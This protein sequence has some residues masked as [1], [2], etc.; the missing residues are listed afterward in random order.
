MPR[1][2]IL[3]DVHANLEAFEAVL[4]DLEE[5][6]VGRIYY[7][8]DVVV[9]GPN[10][11]ECVR[12]LKRALDSWPRSVAIR[13]NNDDAIAS[14]RLSLEPA[15]E[16]TELG[17]NE[18]ISTRH[19]SHLNVPRHSHEWTANLMGSEE[20]ALLKDLPTDQVIEDP[21]YPF[22][23]VHASPCEP[24]GLLGNYLHGCQ[25]AEEAFLCLVDSRK[26]QTPIRLCFFGHT[27]YAV[28]FR[29]EVETRS[30][31]NCRRLSFSRF[32]QNPMRLELD[33][34]PLLVNPGSV[35]QPRDGDPRAAYAILDTDTGVIEFYRVEYPVEETCRK[36]EQSDLERMTV[37]IL[38]RRL[39]EAS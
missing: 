21:N 34:R 5:R 9:Y 33:D 7:L 29:R 14:G 37:E 1:Y 2:A 6:D 23:L 12:R 32:S 16:L 31:D 39:K 22:R 10:P 19:R 27:H 28:A 11:V 38:Q 18:G 35:G 8:G 26:S 20:L 24:T 36:L 17:I 15:E 13:G 3:S 25:D 4:A 30:Y